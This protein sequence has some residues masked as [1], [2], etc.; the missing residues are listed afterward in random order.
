MRFR[1]E[2]KTAN[3]FQHKLVLCFFLVSSLRNTDVSCTRAVWRP[4]FLTGSDP[5]QET[6]RQNLWVY[7][8]PVSVYSYRKVY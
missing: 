5:T 7:G 4:S 2:N 1:A 8:L 6:G 3:E